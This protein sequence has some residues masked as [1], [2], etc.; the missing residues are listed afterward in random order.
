M[1]TPTPAP[2]PQRVAIRINLKTWSNRWNFIRAALL[3]APVAI[4][5]VDA[6]H[7]SI[8]G[9]PAGEY[10]RVDSEI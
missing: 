4:M 5:E 7:A 10:R 6:A 1:S 3:R 2:T 9:N 8:D